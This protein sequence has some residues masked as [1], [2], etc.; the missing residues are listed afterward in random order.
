[1]TPCRGRNHRGRPVGTGDLVRPAAQRRQVA[2][3]SRRPVRCGDRPSRSATSVAH[4]R[5]WVAQ[6]SAPR[7]GR[8]CGAAA[9]DN[10]QAQKIADRLNQESPLDAPARLYWLPA[11]RAQI[12]LNNGDAHRAI[13][14]L[15]DTL[16]YQLGAPPLIQV[17]TL[18]P[19]Y[20][21][22]KAYFTWGQGVDAA[23][24]FQKFSDYRGIVI[25][26]P[27]A[28]LAHL[29]EGRAYALSGDNSK[30]CMKYQDFFALWKDADADIP[31]LKE[32][33]LECEN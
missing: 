25:N 23:A 30:A 32:A 21:R 9:G 27:L 4:K 31:I 7:A 19:A 16:P 13:D 3:A 18:Y 22:G 6:G 26:F 1:M 29:Q 17:G 10:A 24:N 11:T 33:K 12:A 5:F 14:L 20:V 28:S 8:P 15:K 2:L